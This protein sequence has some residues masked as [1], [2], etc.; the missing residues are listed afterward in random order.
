RFSVRMLVKNPGFALIAILTLA[1]GIGVNTAIFSVVNAVLLRPLNYK[2]PER[3]VWV[4]GTLPKFSEANHS[5]AEFE[6]IQTQQTVFS[7]IAAY[8]NT[9][10]TVTGGA[11][12]QQVGGLIAS[13]NYFSLLGVAA[14]PGRAV[15]PGSVRPGV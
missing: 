3:L 5:A 1:L 7:D 2:D 8:H 6:A 14:A 11:Q 9:A 15:Q 10:F 12:P 13:A 4:W